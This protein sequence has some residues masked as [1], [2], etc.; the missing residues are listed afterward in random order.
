MTI[1]RIAFAQLLD[2]T[3]QQITDAERRLLVTTNDNER[4]ALIDELADLN[5]RQSELKALLTEG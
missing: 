5:I 1:S 4:T 3:V 2:V